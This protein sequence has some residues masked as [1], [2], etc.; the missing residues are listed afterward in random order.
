[1]ANDAFEKIKKSV[2]RGITTIGVKTS[3]SLE[4]SKIRVHIAS[5]EKEIQKM[6]CAIGGDAYDIWSNGG[7]DYQKL[8]ERL[9]NVNQKKAGIEQLTTESNSIDDRDDQILGR[10]QEST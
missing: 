10:K 4:K 9:E 3:S 7:S 5:I 2:N 8:I 1:M 6:F